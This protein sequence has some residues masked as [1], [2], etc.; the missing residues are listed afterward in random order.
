MKSI[1]EITWRDAAYSYEKELPD[2]MPGLDKT[3]GHIIEETDEYINIA[4]SFK[5]KHQSETPAYGLIIPKN[6]IVSIKKI[7]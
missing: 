7:N 6:T 2:E 1:Y 5:E 4:T 3:I